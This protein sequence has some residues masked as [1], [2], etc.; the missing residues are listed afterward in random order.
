M[1]IS[2]LNNYEGI[3]FNRLLSSY[4][5]VGTGI[6][7]MPSLI[8]RGAYA[9]VKQDSDTMLYFIY[10]QYGLVALLFLILFF[11]F[12]CNRLRVYNRRARYRNDSKTKQSAQK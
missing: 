8:G 1:K 6:K 9:G 3:I 11:Y 7:S 2:L 5:T 4:T 10:G 12:W